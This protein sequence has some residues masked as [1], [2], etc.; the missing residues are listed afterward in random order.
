MSSSRSVDYGYRR[1]SLWAI[2]CPTGALLLIEK[3]IS[4]ERVGLAHNIDQKSQFLG[5]IGYYRRFIK[6]FSKIADPLINLSHKG[7]SLV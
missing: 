5:F 1:Y 4:G 3:R 2:L 7:V 6:V